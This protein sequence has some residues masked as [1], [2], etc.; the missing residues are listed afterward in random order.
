MLTLVRIGSG[1]GRGGCPI[2]VT[3]SM[4]MEYVM[5]GVPPFFSM[6]L[7]RSRKEESIIKGACSPYSRGRSKYVRAGRR[8]YSCLLTPTE[9][10]CYADGMFR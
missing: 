7:R 4:N 9:Y 2:S 10:G 3:H 5:G 1:I 6:M 8:R